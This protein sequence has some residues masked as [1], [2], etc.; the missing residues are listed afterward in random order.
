MATLTYNRVRLPQSLLS[1]QYFALDFS[2]DLEILI[3]TFVA[4]ITFIRI[5]FMGDRISIKLLMNS[6]QPT[7]DEG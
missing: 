1:S 5:I 3:I 7:K 6:I 2:V 4:G